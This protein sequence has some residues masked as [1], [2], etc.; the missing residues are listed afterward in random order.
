[1]DGQQPPPALL[2]PPDVEQWEIPVRCFKCGGTHTV[3]TRQFMIG[4]VL[5]C[6]HCHKSMVVK[7]NL[8]FQIRTVLKDFC[9][10]WEREAD[11]FLTKREKELQELQAKREKELRDFEKRREQEL[12][13]VKKQLQTVSDSYDAP[14]K[15]GTKKA[16]FGWG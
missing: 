9:E 8:N 6:P 3:P 15:P 1:M 2:T 5:F 13:N 16:F 11:E 7:D 14:G 4:N 10:K 12:E